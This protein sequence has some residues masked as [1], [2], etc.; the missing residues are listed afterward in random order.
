MFYINICVKISNDNPNCEEL[1]E[2]TELKNKLQDSY[3]SVLI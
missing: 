3:S 2:E 1:P